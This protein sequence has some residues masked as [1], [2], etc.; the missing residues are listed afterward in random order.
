VTTPFRIELEGGHFVVGDERADDGPCYV[1]LHG[2]GSVRVGE[3]SASLLEHAIARDHGFLRFDMRGHGESSGEIGRVAVS[4]LIADAIRILER[5]GPAYVIGS[6]LGGLVAAHA[7]GERPDL[8]RRLALLAPAFGLMPRIRDHIDEEGFL[9]TAEG[10]SFFVEPGVRD[11]A[12]R[13]DERGLPRRVTSPTLVVHGTAD[14][15]IPQQVSEW[16]FAS[17]QSRHKELWLVDGGDHRLNTVATEIWQR[18]D[19]LPMP[20][21]A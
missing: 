21:D 7:A 14:D 4:A 19:R 12:E 8:V 9:H 16:F 6:S 20:E 17:M 11:D 13:L 2:L 10:P 18:F 15:I 3:K 1:F 5:T